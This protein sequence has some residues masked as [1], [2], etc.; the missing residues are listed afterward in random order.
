MALFLPQ[1][2]DQMGFICAQL[3]GGE[4]VLWSSDQADLINALFYSLG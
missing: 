3:P 4:G 2:L 1:S